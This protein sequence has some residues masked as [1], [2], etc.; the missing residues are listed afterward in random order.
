[1]IRVEFDFDSTLI[2]LRAK[3]ARDLNGR[4][5]VTPGY[6]DEAV[7]KFGKLFELNHEEHARLVKHLET[8]YGTTQE[9]GSLLRGTFIEW[10]PRAKLKTDRHYWDRLEKFW[11]DRSVLPNDV[12][13]SVNEVTD[14]IMGYLGDPNDK[15]SWNRRRGLVMGH[16]QMGKTTNYSALIS[17]AADAGYRVIIVLAGI[18]NSL[19]YQTQVRL[20]KSF[21]GK[22]SVSDATHTRIY[23]VATVFVGEKDNYSPRHPYCGTSQLSDFNV[24]AARTTGAHEGN[25]ADPIL[26]VTKKNSK[27]LERLAEWLSSLRHGEKLDGPMLL[28]DDEADNASVNTKENPTETTEINKRI[29]DLLHT[30]K[31]STYVGY[32]AT[33][34]ANI[35]IDPDS[36]D[37][38]ERED[39]FP[40]DF[41]KSLEPPTSYVGAKR[42]FSEEADLSDAC[43]REIPDDYQHLLPIKHSPSHVITQL[44]VSLLDAIR[45]FVLFRAVRIVSGYEELHSAMLINVS[46]FNYV[47]GQ[48]KNC[49][50]AFLS[51]TQ[52]AIDAW[53]MSKWEKS[54]S[55]L[56]LKRVWDAEYDGL[57]DFTWDEIRKYL[58]QSIRSINTQLVNMKGG[59]IDYERAPSTGLHVIAIGGLALAR[60]LTLEGLA[61]SYVLRNVGA[62]DTLLQMGRW[63]GYRPGFEQL[64]RI[65]ATPNLIGD[66]R[67]VSDSVE[68][69]RKD[70]ERMDALGKTPFEFGLKVR[71]S[72]TGIAITAANKMRSSQPISLAEDFSERHIQAHTIF[73]DDS[74]N[75]KNYEAAEK[76]ISSGGNNFTCANN[77]LIW[78]K[79]N[80]AVVETFLREIELPQNEFMGIGENRE[81]LIDAYIQDR[82]KNELRDWDIAMP[83]VSKKVNS[84]VDFPFS[85]LAI[86]AGSHGLKYCRSRSNGIRENTGL[87]KITAKNA[88]AFGIDDL[89]YGEDKEKLQKKV[90]TAR[91][92]A[93]ADGIKAPSMNW[94]FASS[95]E[96]PLLVI[97]LLDFALREDEEATNEKLKISS[98]RPTV[99]ISM[100]FP[101]TTIP[102]KERH[103]QASSRLIQMLKD[104]HNELETDEEIDDE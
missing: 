45:E 63:F 29:R 87:V 17:K 22:S 16:V 4:T 90:E 35:F 47:Q 53:S 101:S 23:D 64:C 7:T 39:L 92:N 67:E 56:E 75:K 57:A 34:F 55:L 98:E 30:T 59:G 42:L 26:F 43:V 18:T 20:D 44:P 103:Y 78:S 37:S 65:H 10:Y 28:I 27:V 21:V 100:V 104:Q 102:C 60:G 94:L 5:T 88:V 68:E 49:V 91:S 24:N 85:S 62:A 84:S 36:T 9:N 73:D 72:G 6:L 1:M 13:R 25:F 95:R 96:R 83:F 82:S 97:H 38:W 31:Q 15:S 58:I 3:I 77:A 71:Q 12:I 11:R 19:R 41:I 89:A 86:E 99:T 54:N 52:N 66:F 80:V 70:F 2:Y 46:R 61:V 32:T 74:I 69:L 40:A 48:V 51:D 93:I 76:L 79:A 33:P 81:S 8:I 14:E 50:D